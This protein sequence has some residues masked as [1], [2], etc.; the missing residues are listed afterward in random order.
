VA[1]S[2]SDLAGSTSGAVG[3]GCLAGRDRRREVR[4]EATQR[5]ELTGEREGGR[6]H[7]GRTS[8]SV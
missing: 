3:L 7:K 4:R 8:S 2:A 1:G 5:R 6:P